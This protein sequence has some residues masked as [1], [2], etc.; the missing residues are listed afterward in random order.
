MVY[1]VISSHGREGELLY[2]ANAVND[3]NYVLSYWVQRERWNEVLNVLKKQTDPEVFYRYSSVLM[4]YVAPDLEISSQPFLSTT[5][6]SR[7]V[8]MHRTKPSDTSTM[9]F[10]S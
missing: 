10:I 3:Y 1:D 2:F 9:R 4:T 6:H 5:V 7:E 8:P